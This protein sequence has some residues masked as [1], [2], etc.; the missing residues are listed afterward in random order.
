MVT[1][2]SLA[3]RWCGARVWSAG[4]RAARVWLF[5][6]ASAGAVGAAEVREA[7]AAYY[8][9]LTVPIP[10]DIVLEAGAMQFLPDGRLAV[11][12]RH[13][14]IYLVHGALSDPPTPDR[15]RFE[16]F[17]SGLHEVLGLAWRDGWLYATQ[18]GELTCMRDMDGDQR[19]DVF[20]TVSD[21]WSITGDYHEYAFGSKFDRDGYLW[22]VLCLTGSYTSDAPFRGWCVRVSPKGEMIPA[23][24]GLRSPGGIGMNAVGDMF[25]TDNQGV[26]NGTSGL[27]HLVPGKFMGNPAGNTWYSIA[28]NMGPRPRDPESGTR[29]HLAAKQIPELVPTAVYFPYDKMGQSASGI[30]CDLSHGKFGP[31]ESQLFVGDQT[32]STVMRVALEKVKDR[33]QGALFPFREGFDSGN[34]SLEFAGD[35]SLFVGGTDRGWGAR[36]GKPFALQRLVWTGATPFEVQTM[37]AQADGF[38]LAFTAPVDPA[39]AT[40]RASYTIETYT[41]IYQSS[42]G[43]PEVDRTRP[44][45]ERIELASDQRSVR[46]LVSQ[47]QI[48]HVHELHLRGV[49][50]SQGQ[51]LRHPVAYYTLNAVPAR[52]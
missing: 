36:G 44:T 23:C 2:T 15:V 22:V 33:Y 45:I 43:S 27:K 39:T 46:L 19:A 52:E 6:L 42:Y 5:A 10:H 49:R 40:N 31:F 25:Y 13:G 12:T 17:A 4:L 41:Y 30:A 47:L 8:R 48:G 28:G 3:V 50:S 51:P 21:G 37:S 9:L 32:H 26:W 1:R 7:E 34:L 18:R 16:H 24:S 14:D 38:R 20:E 29:M 35:G 11:A